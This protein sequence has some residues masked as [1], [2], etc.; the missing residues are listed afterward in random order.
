MF[1][2]EYTP[3]PEKAAKEMLKEAGLKEGDLLY[4]LS[5]GDGKLPIMAA[6][7]FGARCIGIERKEALANEA[8][9]KVKESGLEDRITILW[10]N[11]HF[12][13]YWAHLGGK[14]EEKP[15]AI[16][17]ADVVAYYLTLFVQEQLRPKLVKELR[18]GARVAS[19]AFKLMGWEPVK[20]KK[21]DEVPF[22]IFEKGK[23][24]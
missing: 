9:K 17:K 23:S 6:K 2:D 18:P 10:D 19:Y 5:C 15:Y 12:S 24:F 1:I 16:R 8:K 4:V 14:E 20:T 21:V 22:F 3:I 13:Q 11:F 7:E